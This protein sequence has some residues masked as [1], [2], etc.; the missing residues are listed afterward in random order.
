MAGTWCP[1]TSSEPVKVQF[2]RW[3]SYRPDDGVF[4]L[5]KKGDRETL[6]T[7]GAKYCPSPDALVLRIVSDP[8]LQT[9]GEPMAAGF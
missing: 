1:L 3:R 5:C 9:A 7:E 8:N 2:F 4:A 6:V